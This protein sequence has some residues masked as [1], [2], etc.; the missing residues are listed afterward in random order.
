VGLWL[1]AACCAPFVPTLLGLTLHH[2][3]E[4]PGAAVGLTGAAGMLG[5]LLASP[6]LDTSRPDRPSRNA[7]RGAVALALLLLV[8]ALVLA[9]LGESPLT[10]VSNALPLFRRK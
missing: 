10:E 1:T 3:P 7:L 4:C 9:V 8:P 6:L 2:H 5:I